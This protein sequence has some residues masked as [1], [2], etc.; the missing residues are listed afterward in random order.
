MGRNQKFRFKER[1]DMWKLVVLFDYRQSIE[2]G[3]TACLALSPFGVYNIII[4]LFVCHRHYN[5]NASLT[6]LNVLLSNTLRELIHHVVKSPTEY[7]HLIL[8][9][10]RTLPTCLTK[11]SVKD[12]PIIW[13][14]PWPIFNLPLA[15]VLLSAGW[16]IHLYIH[17]C[18]IY[19]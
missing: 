14:K 10:E 19:H 8:L 18:M 2:F 13:V 1:I 7:T 6:F 15:I 12:A 11:L 17:V 3:H 4:V 9:D 16:K 5:M